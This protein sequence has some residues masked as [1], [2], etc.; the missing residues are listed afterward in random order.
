[1]QKYWQT[2]RTGN[3]GSQKAEPVATA[4][5]RDQILASLPCSIWR[6]NLCLLGALHGRRGWLRLWNAATPELPRGYAAGYGAC[7]ALG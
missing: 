3:T 6:G 4:H 1:M 5:G 7:C 2:A